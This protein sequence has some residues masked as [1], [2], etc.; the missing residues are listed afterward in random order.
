MWPRDKDPK[1]RVERFNIRFDIY[2]P[3]GS[4]RIDD[5]L[6]LRSYTY[7]QFDA[8]VK[9]VPA[10]KIETAY[11]FSYDI[12]EPIEVDETTEDVVYILKRQA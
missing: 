2:K 10:W 3:T 7:K 8:L 6:V 9:K 1:A 4:M 5:C 11:D 12:D